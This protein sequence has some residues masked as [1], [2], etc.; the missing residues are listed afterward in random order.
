MKRLNTYVAMYE[1]RLIA[2]PIM[3]NETLMA[4]ITLADSLSLAI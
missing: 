2:T 3:N 1:I 4:P